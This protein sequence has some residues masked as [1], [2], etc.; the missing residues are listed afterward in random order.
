MV[1]DY[2]FI[3]ISPNVVHCSY[4]IVLSCKATFRPDQLFPNFG[5][6]LF[7]MNL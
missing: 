2:Y 4:N 6:K 1:L 7:I 3:Y 5:Q